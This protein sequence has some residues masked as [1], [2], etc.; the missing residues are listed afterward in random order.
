MSNQEKEH[1]PD[2]H[3][4]AVISGQQ[5]SEAAAR[6]LQSRGFGHALLFHGDEVAEKVDPKGEHS[7]PIGRVVKAVQDHLSEEPDYLE[8]YQEEARAGN[9][10]VAVRV[11]DRDQA[12]AVK[13][14]LEQHGARNV[15]F[16]GKLAV[17]D[18]SLTTNP[19]ARSTEA[20]E[21]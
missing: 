12:E 8:Q 21:R 13:E 16:F 9:E 4:V 18:L 20:P 1:I 11:D 19:S 14:I 5:A 6:D 2:N 15:R 3:V 17:T 7:G 10:V